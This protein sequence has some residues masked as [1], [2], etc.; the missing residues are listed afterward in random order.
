LERNAKVSET[1]S[2]KNKSATKWVKLPNK[3]FI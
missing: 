2:A 3:A 1:T